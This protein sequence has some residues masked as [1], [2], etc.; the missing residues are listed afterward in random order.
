MAVYRISFP[1]RKRMIFVIISFGQ[2]RWKTRHSCTIYLC[3]VE[4]FCFEHSILSMVYYTVV[5]HHA[6]ND[7]RHSLAI[8]QC[9][10][11]VDFPID[12][13]I[14]RDFFFIHLCRAHF[15]ENLPM[16]KLPPLSSVVFDKHIDYVVPLISFQSTTLY[17]R[18]N[19]LVRYVLNFSL[20][21]K[22]IF[23]RVCTV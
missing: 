20:D 15:R 14:S 1:P 13:H 4:Y 22:I 7:E 23:R 19:V 6:L 16:Q 18:W 5:W 3:T 10:R 21:N 8:L 11:K 9:E 12:A 2:F 17:M